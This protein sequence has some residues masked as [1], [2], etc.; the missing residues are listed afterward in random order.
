MQHCLKAKNLLEYPMSNI[1]FPISN[2]IIWYWYL[3]EIGIIGN[4]SRLKGELCRQSI[5]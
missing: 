3:F 2:A 1:K 5:N 4:Y